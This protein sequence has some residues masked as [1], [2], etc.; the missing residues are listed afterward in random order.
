MPRFAL[1][2]LVAA[3]LLLG[4]AR[5]AGAHFA[6]KAPAPWKKMSKQQ[7]ARWLHALK[8]NARAEARQG[9]APKLHRRQARQ[10]ERW[11][12]KLRRPAAPHWSF[13]RLTQIWLASK[14]ASVSAGDPW[15]NCPDPFAGGGSW[16]DM[17]RCE[18]RGTFESLGPRAWGVDPP[19]FYRCALQ[20]D[21]GWEPRYSSE[22]RQRFGVSKVCPS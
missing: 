15:P 19:G 10:A 18:A 14:I 11:L 22:L 9:V 16:D 5:P 21:P 17:A 4:A 12:R 2:A 8:R 13:W 3:A 1:L 20:F 7:K 6:P